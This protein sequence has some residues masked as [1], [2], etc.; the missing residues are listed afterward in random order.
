MNEEIFTSVDK[1]KSTIL[2][3]KHDNI[4]SYKQL[5]GQRWLNFDEKEYEFFENILNIYPDNKIFTIRI[6]FHEEHPIPQIVSFRSIPTEKTYDHDFYSKEQLEAFKKSLA[7]P[8]MSARITEKKPFKGLIKFPDGLSLEYFDRLLN[9]LMSTD[10]DMSGWLVVSGG[11][12]TYDII[13][14]EKYEYKSKK[15]L[16]KFIKTLKRWSKLVRKDIKDK[17][18]EQIRKSE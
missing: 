2:I 11:D 10:V 16:K 15:T 3:M 5:I 1:N 17:Q 14:P 12:D 4:L 8:T 7:D 9:H 6:N 13:T 18:R